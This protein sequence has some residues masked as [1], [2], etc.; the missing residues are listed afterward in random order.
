[1]LTSESKVWA[2]GRGERLGEEDEEVRRGEE[3]RRGRRGND[4]LGKTVRGSGDAVLVRRGEVAP[5]EVPRQR[6]H[7]RAAGRRWGDRRGRLCEGG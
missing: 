1:M 2:T 3:I 5:G 7:G 4:D 6:G